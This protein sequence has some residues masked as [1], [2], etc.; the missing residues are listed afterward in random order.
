[1]AVKVIPWSMLDPVYKAKFKDEAEYMN[2]FVNTILPDTDSK[3]KYIAS[4][5]EKIAE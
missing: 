2:F 5:K 1:M 4:T 3:K